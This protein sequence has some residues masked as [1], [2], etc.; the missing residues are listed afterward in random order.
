M[1]GVLMSTKISFVASTANTQD[2]PGWA[3]WKGG[4]DT[5]LMAES[6]ELKSLLMKVKWRG[7]WKSW[8]KTQ[9]SEN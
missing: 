4:D 5:T 9:P 2:I 6:E 3:P 8:L 7:E 1:K